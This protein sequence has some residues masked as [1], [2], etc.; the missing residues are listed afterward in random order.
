M[1]EHHGSTLLGQVLVSRGLITP[2]ELG[3]ALCQQ[4]WSGEPLGQI[5]MEMGALAPNQLERA[6]Q[7]QARLRS[8]SAAG[9]PLVLVVEDDPEAGAVEAE[10]LAGAGYQVRVAQNEA[11]AMAAMM[12]PDQARPEVMVLDL[13]LPQRGGVELLT[14]LRKNGG[15]QRVPVVILSDHPEMEEQLRERGLEVSEFLSKPT[16]AHRLVEAVRRALRERA[17]CEP[18]GERTP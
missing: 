2:E 11:E 15:T 16:P 17:A 3:Q 6:L 10:I 7:E 13:A 4:R 5:L 14:V 12:A 8:E 9:Q 18:V 1:S